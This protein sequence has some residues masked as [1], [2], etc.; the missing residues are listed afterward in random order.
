MNKRDAEFIL[1]VQT[2]V[3]EYAQTHP[4]IIVPCQKHNRLPCAECGVGNG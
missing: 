1:K 3:R 4:E 2:L